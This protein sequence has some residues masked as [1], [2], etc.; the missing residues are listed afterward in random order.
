MVMMNNVSDTFIEKD[1]LSEWSPEKKITL[2]P[3]MA[4]LLHLPHPPT[5]IISLL[6]THSPQS[7]CSLW[8]SSLC[9]V[10]FFC[11]INANIRLYKRGALIYFKVFVSF[12]SCL[13]QCIISASFLL[14]KFNF[15]TFRA[16]LMVG[17]RWN[18]FIQLDEIFF[19]FF[20]REELILFFHF[21]CFGV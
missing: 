5:I 20:L 12:I 7:L 6:N 3:P 2:F 4:Y 21:R 15:C 19:S 18:N 17:I 16:H 10:N 13:N 8:H 11:D 9:G 1:H 14:M